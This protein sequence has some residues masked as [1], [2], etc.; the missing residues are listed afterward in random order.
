MITKQ[1]FRQDDERRRTTRS[2]GGGRD[3][4]AAVNAAKR[5]LPKGIGKGWRAGRSGPRTGPRPPALSLGQHRAAFSRAT[6]YLI[7]GR[8]GAYGRDG[9]GRVE[10]IHALNVNGQDVSK[11]SA[12]ELRGLAGWMSETA[13][14]NKSISDSAC[15]HFVVSPAPSDKE[16]IAAD[17]DFFLKYTKRALQELGMEGHQAALVIHTDTDTPHCHIIINRVNPTTGKACNPWMPLIK[18]EK[19]NRQI[20][21]EY[22]LQSV[23]GRHINAQSLR[24]IP[25]DAEI[26][27]VRHQL[28]A[29]QEQQFITDL[30]K[31]LKDKP[32]SSTTSW[33]EL[34]ARLEKDGLR[35]EARG[36]GLML[37]G[38]HEI[39][40]QSREVAV[41]LS[42]IA[43]KS[44]NKEVLAEKFGQ[45]LGD[46]LVQTG[47]KAAKPPPPAPEIVEPA[48]KK[49]KSR[50]RQWPPI[51]QSLS[52][53]PK[54]SEIK[55]VSGITKLHQP[56]PQSSEK[57]PSPAVASRADNLP[58]LPS[59]NLANQPGRA[60]GVLPDAERLGVDDQRA[61]P[62]ARLRWE[63]EG[64][65]AGIESLSPKE[66]WLREVRGEVQHAA[67][68]SAPHARAGK[69]GGPLMIADRPHLYPGS[70]SRTD[71]GAMLA[72]L[73]PAELAELAQA[74]ATAIQ[75]TVAEVK[76]LPPGDKRRMDANDRH[77]NLEAASKL[78]SGFLPQQTAPAQIAAPQPLRINIHDHDSIKKEAVRG[79]PPDQLQGVYDATIKARKGLGK[80]TGVDAARKKMEMTEG[81]LWIE[82]LAP[83]MG[84]E[85][86]KPKPPM[87]Q[88][89][90]PKRLLGFSFGD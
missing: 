90:T 62:A 39:G 51:F 1:I 7:E 63:R 3:D 57:G 73:S 16:K 18:L 41:K 84:V 82:K 22:G 48:P 61:E 64:S 52:K 11:I 56:N 13:A 89:R 2:G 69:L 86:I 33:A 80:E 54:L 25:R 5:H 49:A 23:Q 6:N 19:L 40:G 38:R 68:A 59:S 74:Q 47:R 55:H 70:M 83:E 15:W 50:P 42:R 66:Q 29:V 27:K 14:H 17:P 78:L 85:L 58:I 45:D 35:L 12:S 9:D 24:A 75:T 79:I 81:L 44:G 88:Q 34:E 87:R 36:R 20:E 46:W 28:D 31:R 71:A 30:R 65:G 67:V 76:S 60:E 72:G 8:D 43:G 21:Q 4:V 26:P 10:S 32:F 77:K 37:V 53:I